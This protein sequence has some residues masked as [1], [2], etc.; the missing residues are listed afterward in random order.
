[1]ALADLAATQSDNMLEPDQLEELIAEDLRFRNTQLK[2]LQKEVLDLEDLED[3]PSLTSFSLED[4]RI[5]LL[6]FLESRREELEQAPLGLYA[7]VPPPKDVRPSVQPGAL[8]CLRR[9]S[10]A[11][12]RSVT[13]EKLNPL[14]PHFLLYVHDDGVVRYSFAQPKETLNLLRSLAAGHPSALRQWC[15][16]FD[17]ATNGGSDMSHYD[18]LVASALRT[19]E[20][21]FRKRAA[22]T[23]LS[24]RDGL[25]PT[26][27]E[28]AHADDG[29][30]ELVTW[31]VVLG[32]QS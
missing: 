12:Q 14:A 18:A 25:L 21:T 28:S 27:G 32:D 31:I 13:G 15:D 29:D 26:L 7:V 1:M 24:G 4:F 3:A 22:T 16:R 19:I 5:E 30:W 6:Q 23:L 2:R 11:E 9:A 10:Q 8:F 20:T 17:A